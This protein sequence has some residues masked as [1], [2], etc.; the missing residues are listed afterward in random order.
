VLAA[1]RTVIALRFKG[2]AAAYRAAL[3]DAGASVAVA[4]GILGDSLRRAEIEAGLRVR[5]PLASE[6]ASFYF[7]FPELLA[8]RVKATPAPWW[9]GGRKEGIALSSLAPERVFKVQTGRT[10]NVRSLDGTYAVRMLGEPM[11][12]GALPLDR[13][14][15]AISA[16]LTAFARGAAFERWTA[17]RQT[18]ALS[19]TT[20]LR[21]EMPAPGPLD[22]TTLL[23]F[24]SLTGA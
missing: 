9:L 7:A 21:D 3:A 1:E 6:I 18:F 12:L 14:R 5:T 2:S 22:L 19:L 20:C 11:P 24:L 4:R 8:R 23:P 13:A 10:A 17:A 16:A 15:P